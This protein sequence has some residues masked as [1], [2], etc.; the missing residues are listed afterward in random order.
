MKT[1]AIIES[2]DTKYIEA[3]YM[4]SCIEKAGIRALV[5]N[6]S[7]GP[8]ECADPEDRDGVV[9]VSRG[10]IAAAYGTPWSELESKT[11]GEK[12]EYM[13]KA[14]TAYVDSLYKAGSIQGIISVGGLQNTVMATAA[15]SVLPIGFPKVMATTVA[16]GTKQFS[17]VVGDKDIV[18]IPTICDCTGL[19]LIT[20]RVIA[21]ACGCCIGMVQ[22]AGEPIAKGDKPV[23]GLTLMG[24]TNN[25]AMAAV[26]ALEEAGYEVLGFHATGVGGAV[27]EQMAADGLI[28]GVLDLT[29]HEITS[30]YFGGGFSYGPGAATRLLKSTASRAPLVVSLGGIDFVDYAKKEAHVVPNLESRK[31]YDHNADT[32]HIKISPEEAR[33][34]GKIVA[35]RLNTAD[36]PAS[37]PVKLLIPTDGMRHNTTSGEALYDPEADQ[38]LIESLKANLNSGIE[39]IE[40]EGNLDTPEWGRKAARV[41][42]DVL[43][44]AKNA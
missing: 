5:L 15:M 42:L 36:Y 37:C 14:V 44:A 3:G 39:V 4:K 32:V 10:E 30:E 20:R 9:D 8:V 24:V 2:C 34:I 41:M 11:K 43:R 7:T 31:T 40:I 16:S 27:M 33:D 12:I 26:E 21:N 35:T 22:T 23:I 29:L 17:L 6:T 28:D 38:A 13:R 19:N 1:I 25:G 18:A